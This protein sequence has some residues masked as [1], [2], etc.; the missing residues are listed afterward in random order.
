MFNLQQRVVRR[1]APGAFRTWC[2]SPTGPFTVQFYCGGIK[3]VIVLANIGDLYIPGERISSFQ[4]LGTSGLT[5]PWRP[6][7]SASLATAPKSSPS[8]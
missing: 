1:L 5:Q 3:W 6:P 2:E 4:Q 8:T 7:D